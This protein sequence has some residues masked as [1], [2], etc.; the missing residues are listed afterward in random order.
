MWIWL[1]L[2]VQ[3][4]KAYTHIFFKYSN[5]VLEF[6]WLKLDKKHFSFRLDLS[7][8]IINKNIVLAKE[9]T[10][11]PFVFHLGYKD[12]YLINQRYN[13][14]S[15]CWFREVLIYLGTFVYKHR[16]FGNLEH[17][18]IILFLYLT[19]LNLIPVCKQRYL[20]SFWCLLK[21]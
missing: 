16:H 3:T 2:P 11:Y 12:T 15:V 1:W 20:I 10:F 14:N 9:I 13:L 21:F 19:N 8:E 6:I 7:R 5:L 17:L 18:K 4:N